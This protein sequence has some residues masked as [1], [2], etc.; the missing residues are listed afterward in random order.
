MSWQRREPREK[1][2][3]LLRRGLAAIGLLCCLGTAAAAQ[4]GSEAEEQW[5]VTLESGRSALASGNAVVAENFLLKAIQ[6][7]MF[8]HPDMA[9]NIA[10]AESYEAMAQ[11]QAA[12]EDYGQAEQYMT[13][14]IAIR[15]V[16][17]PADH[18]DL[19]RSVLLFA[20][21]QRARGN[22]AEAD[23]LY[24]SGLDT[25]ATALGPAHPL[26]AR[27]YYGLALSEMAQGRTDVAERTLLR[28]I[29][30]LGV[31]DD[32]A[33][34]ENLF[35]MR[36][37]AERYL[38]L[39]QPDDAERALRQGLDLYTRHFVADHP[40]FEATLLR[41][42][43]IQL[44]R[45]RV[46]AA[47]ETLSTGSDRLRGALGPGSERAAAVMERIGELFRTYAQPQDAEAYFVKAFEI[48]Q[49]SRGATASDEVRGLVKL[50]DLYLQQGD[51]ARAEKNY[52]DA[53]QIAETRLP[54]GSVETAYAYSNLAL[55]LWDRGEIAEA[56]R[57]WTDALA[58]YESTRPNDL[59][60]ATVAFNLG[61]LRHGQGDYVGA[62]PLYRRAL[63]IRLD[64]LGPG[65][66]S[67]IETINMYSLLL[68]RVGRPGEAAEV[69]ALA[70]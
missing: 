30:V 4:S 19:G 54:P 31:Q 65:D 33:L 56:A 3:G 43:T 68:E 45:G 38:A 63:D 59:N 35:D 23:R 60:T 40:F 8:L 20:D 64:Q 17:Q 36:P 48:R 16:A 7:A 10:L 44:E 6:D 62:E 14:A 51:A 24:R 52:R 25:I 46:D 69:R 21:L 1:T 13:Q 29:A 15:R 70:N 42:G 26:L 11:V 28:G 47:R 49:R 2:P 32:T 53:V 37:F 18:P 61:Q 39:G 27:A 55:I 12:L 9:T 5:R 34:R 41:L 57:L 58:I 50:G 67:T 22:Y 66:P